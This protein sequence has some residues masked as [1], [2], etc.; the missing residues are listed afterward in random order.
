MDDFINERFSYAFDEKYGYLTTFPTNVG[1]GLKACVVLHLPMLSQV[2]KF[3]SIVGDM[4][5]LG[6]AI[7]GALREGSENYGNMYELSNQR[8]LGQSEREIIEQ[9]AKAATQLNNQELRVR[10][11]ALNARRLER[12]D[13]TW[14]SYGILKICQKDYG[15]GCQDLFV[16]AYGGR[17]RRRYFL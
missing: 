15:K 1:T 12:E 13:E 10:N 11:A 14:K 8:S 16:P 9:V 17:G 6:T 5:R 7:P 4:G 3:Q 2:R